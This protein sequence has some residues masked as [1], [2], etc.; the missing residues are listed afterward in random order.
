VRS[1]LSLVL[2]PKHVQFTSLRLPV[3]YWG[4]R[5]S[6]PLTKGIIINPERIALNYPSPVI[7]RRTISHSRAGNP[8]LEPHEDKL[9]L[10]ILPLAGTNAC[11]DNKWNLNPLERAQRRHRRLQHKVVATPGLR[12]HLLGARHQR[13]QHKVVG[14]AGLRHRLPGGPPSMFLQLQWWLL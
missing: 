1:L 7:R 3:K 6:A 11:W 2:Y 13:Q 9:L 5:R 4:P 14:T 10:S 8:G 12:H